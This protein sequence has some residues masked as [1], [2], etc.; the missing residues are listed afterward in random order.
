MSESSGSPGEVS[1]DAVAWAEQWESTRTLELLRELVGVAESVSPTVA[2]RAGLSVTE[3]Q[4]L[5]LIAERPWG[6]ADLSRELHVT[7]AATSGIVDRLVARGHAVRSPHEQDRR[8][9]VVSISDS[10]RREV[11]GHLL[12]MFMGLAE[13][14]AALSEADREVVARYLE[15]AIAALRRVL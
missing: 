14:D 4:V 7:S 9:T 13:V 8:R 5:E 2:R 1:T 11:L 6:P 15:G 10:G 12:P 3:L